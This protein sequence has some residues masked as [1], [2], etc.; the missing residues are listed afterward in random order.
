[1]GDR[2]KWSKHKLI[3]E[4]HD[5]EQRLA[6]MTDRVK[7]VQ[8][9]AL[10]EYEQSEARRGVITEYESAINHLLEDRE[11][12]LVNLINT[13]EF[14]KQQIDALAVYRNELADKLVAVRKQEG[15]SSPRT[16]LRS[17]QWDSDKGWVRTG[18]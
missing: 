7:Q 2:K 18:R 16:L 5:L 4:I 13:A 6:H 15:N 11:R 8:R 12:L 10:E 3:D 1:M 14:A 17:W 9:E